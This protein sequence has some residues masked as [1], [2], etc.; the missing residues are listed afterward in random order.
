MLGRRLSSPRAWGCFCN[1]Q[2]VLLDGAVFPTRVGVFLV[3]ACGNQDCKCL[4]H[5]RGGVSIRQRHTGDR[6]ESSP[7]AWGCFPVSSGYLYFGQV[8]PTRVGVFPTRVE[9][10]LLQERLPHARGGVSAFPNDDEKLFRSSPRA[11]GC[12]L[13][14]QRPRVE[15]L[16]FPTR[17][18]VFLHVR[19]DLIEVGGLPHARGGVSFK[20][21]RDE[22]V[23]WSSPRAWGCFSGNRSPRCPQ[24]VFPT[25][26]GVFLKRTKGGRT[27]SGLPHARGGVSAGR[28]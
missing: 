15:R 9:T 14:H 8:F 5:A 10:P 25:R 16:V 4:P 3:C 7:R 24:G 18:G 11:W 23:A 27:S 20:A 2:V 1:R 12:F 22:P 19:L 13:P 21:L 17:V 26:V 28:S 6:S